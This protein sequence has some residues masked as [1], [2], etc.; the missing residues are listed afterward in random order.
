MV[1][2]SNIFVYLCS[3]LSLLGGTSAHSICWVQS[4]LDIQAFRIPPVWPDV[5][6]PKM[7]NPLCLVLQGT[8]PMPQG[9]CTPDLVPW[10]HLHFSSCIQQQ[11]CWL[12]DDLSQIKK[13]PLELGEQWHYFLCYIILY[14]F[15]CIFSTCYVLYVAIV[16]FT[17]RSLIL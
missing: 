16:Q 9:T 15:G 10:Y 8:L 1:S 4:R 13:D 7:A 3:K 5:I 14:S 12:V 11:I 17:Y 2:F 6:K